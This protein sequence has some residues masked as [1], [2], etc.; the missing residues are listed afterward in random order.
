MEDVAFQRRRGT[1][2]RESNIQGNNVRVIIEDQRQRDRR[3]ASIGRVFSR[4]TD[5]MLSLGRSRLVLRAESDRGWALAFAPDFSGIF[6]FSDTFNE[7]DKNTIFTTAYAITAISGTLAHSS[8][9]VHRLA[10]RF[11]PFRDNGNR[12]D[13]NLKPVLP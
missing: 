2:A 3:P 11:Y 6:V 7:G 10:P 1:G 8:L 4:A 12:G 5:V 13:K 9:F